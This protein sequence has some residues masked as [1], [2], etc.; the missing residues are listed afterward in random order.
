MVIVI[1][2]CKITR[3]GQDPPLQL[4]LHS[5]FQCGTG[6]GGQIDF[7]HSV[8]HR[9]H[10]GLGQIITGNHPSLLLRPGKKCPCALGGGGIVH[11]KYPN[12]GL[13]PHSHIITNRQIH[14]YPFLPVGEGLDPPVYEK[15][16]R[17][18]FY[19]FIETIFIPN[20]RI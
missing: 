10:I 12:N 19:Q 18:F 15:L 7:I 6:Q 5:L 16:I 17:I 9:Q 3:E 4:L 1:L 13:F 8:F 11:I 20:L 14:I 2:Y